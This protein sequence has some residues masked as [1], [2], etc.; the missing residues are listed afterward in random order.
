M[1]TSDLLK[2][3]EAVL[4]KWETEG[5]HGKVTE[6]NRGSRLFFFLEGP[7]Y[8]NGELHMGHVRGYTRKDAILRY[9]RMNGFDVFDRAGFD[10]HGLPTENRVERNLGI[11][12][13][14]DI[15]AKIGVRE[16]IGKCIESYKGYVKEQTY[17]AK[18]YGVWFD[19]ENAYIP[20]EP[21]YIDKSFYVF[22]RIYDKGLIYKDI[23]VMPYCIHC[24]TV[25]A[26]GPEVEEEEDTDP[27]VYV[28]FMVDRNASKSKISMQQD[29]YLLIWTTTPWTIPAN[30]AVAANPKELYVKVRLGGRSLILAKARFQA[31]ASALNESAVVE[32]EFYG[33]ELDGIRY[34]N[35]LEGNIPA[36][37]E[38]RRHHRVIFSEGMVSMADGTGLIHIAPA[39]GPEDFDIS[40]KE[41]IP[42][43]S[44]VGTDGR[45]TE[46][47]GKYAGKALIHEANREVEEELS[48]AGALLLKSTITH[49]YPHCW[50]C[51]E[52]LVY[53]PT[54][55][56]F[57][58]VAKIKNKIR[59][60]CDR[61]EWHPAELKDWFLE[62]I[63]TAPDWVIS[64]Q[65]YW[66]IPIPIWTCDSCGNVTAIGSFGELSTRSPTKIEFTSEDLH[67]PTVDGIVL[68][69][70][71]CGGEMHRVRDIFDVWYDSGVAH[72]AS[73]SE[74]EFGRMFSKA[75]IT[76]GL[77]QLRGWFA[78]LMKTSVGAYGKS[79][80]RVIMAHGWVNDAKGEAMHKSKGNYVSAKQLIG[81][82]STDAVRAYMLS[83]VVHEG[84]K[85][86]YG[87][88]EDMQATLLLLHNVANLVTEYSAAL[89]RPAGKSR[90]PGGP[91]GLALYDAW[92]VSRLN[93]VMKT[94]TE[95]M[96]GY[97][98]NTGLNE[99]LSFV[100][101][102]LSRFYLKIAKKKMSGA[103]RKEA[104]ATFNT[105]NYVFRNTVLLLAPV[106][107]L[108]MEDIYMK[109]YGGKGSVFFERW[110]KAKPSL[111]NP[112]LEVDFSAAQ[113]AIT[114][115]LN[116]RER[117]GVPLRWPIASATLE[118]T[119]DSTYSSLQRLSTVIEDYV[120][121]KRLELKRVAGAKREARP[122]FA[123]LGPDFKDKAVYVADA[124][125]AADAD[126]MLDSV[127]RTGRYALSTGKGPVEITQEHFTTTER[128]EEKDAVLFRH[129]KAHIDANITRGL[130]EEALVREFEHEVQ[131][132]RK[133]L[134]LRK[135]DRISL[136]YVAVGSIA[137]VIAANAKKIARDVNSTKPT[138]RLEG[139]VV[140]DL[141][142]AGE[143]VK[144]AVDRV[145]RAVRKTS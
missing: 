47:A 12:S 120:N 31:V 51:H 50:R 118:V 139:S 2:I 97:E 19:F 108:N 11:T 49:S 126:A 58:N 96:D 75:F 15:E 127:A 73:L 74:E 48:A 10:V 27:S 111:I 33:S 136:G 28:A 110:P 115:L 38:H 67:R 62:S 114:A 16:F 41:R 137:A 45:Y 103:S 94:M 125:R 24:G 121:A 112:G 71:K 4:Q 79:P 86:M 78:T 109:V 68:K 54:E 65:R 42:L 81:R 140:K 144:V 88:I 1:Q 8:A 89:N 128:V 134:G 60:E 29:T 98:P 102:D 124:I 143:T 23:R 20:A 72:T 129:G 22:K 92:I 141:D 36:Q 135:T 7:P 66:D 99:T 69:C 53:L 104:I 80:F 39:Y 35:P 87:E 132:I 56:W 17:V 84:I 138:N 25:L 117:M 34:L 30:M 93:S 37:R 13:K 131:T 55:Q 145:E 116:S 101:N 91:E 61:I 14:R 21:G 44:M 64:R 119:D 26:K 82:Y 123:R 113:D 5:T 32:A 3:E 57:M 70:D 18:R 52:K 83:H 43:L 85:F 130:K 95:T 77:D 9:K 63:N 142:M 46:V 100:I 76:E 40:R 59:K 106:M 133:E 90:A 122:I 6:M 105:L 107:P